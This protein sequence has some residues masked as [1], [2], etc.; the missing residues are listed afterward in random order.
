MSK[1]NLIILISFLLLLIG[2]LLLIALCNINTFKDIRNLKKNGQLVYGRVTDYKTYKDMHT[3]ENGVLCE[4]WLFYEYQE[5]D[6]VW[7][8]SERWV[9]RYYD[10]E[11]ANWCKEQ[12]GKRIE[13]LIN[14][15]GNCAVAH[16]VD[17]QYDKCFGYVVI[18]GSTAGALEIALIICL[19]IVLCKKK[20]I[21]RFIENRKK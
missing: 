9:T 3:V 16:N 8:T 20:P 18:M 4:Y 13:L 17:Y 1:K 5:D 12:V 6:R 2:V 10:E 14:D 11:K 21:F 15:N 7:K 19:I